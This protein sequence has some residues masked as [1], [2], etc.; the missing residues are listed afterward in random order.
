[1]QMDGRMPLSTGG[2]DEMVMYEKNADQ[3]P[4]RNAQNCSQENTKTNFYTFLG[5]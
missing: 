5:R 3:A 1:M 4:P 2:F